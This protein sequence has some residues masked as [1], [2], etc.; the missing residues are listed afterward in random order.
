[1]GVNF[2]QNQAYFF[3]A[4]SQLCK[5][6]PKTLKKDSKNVENRYTVEVQKRLRNLNEFAS[7][8]TRVV[9][10]RTGGANGFDE[11]PGSCLQC[12]DSDC[13]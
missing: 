13:E 6:A 12:L 7:K 2:E 11:R 8:L 10:R 1:M 5:L 4:L 9:L 3:V